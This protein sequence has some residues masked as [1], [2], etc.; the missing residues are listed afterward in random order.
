MRLFIRNM[1]HIIENKMDIVTTLKRPFWKIKR[2]FLYFFP[3][4]RRIRR[5]KDIHKGERC[6]IIGN[7]PSL[8][9]EDLSKLKE[10]NE[11]TFAFN[12]IFHIFEKTDW[13]PTYY[14]TQDVSMMHN[15]Q[16]EINNIPAKAK[17]IPIENKYYKG[18][19]LINA[20]YYHLTNSAIHPEFSEDCSRKLYGSMTVVY[21]AL[22]MAVYMGIH[23][24]YLIGVDHHFNRS[25][26]LKGEIVIDNTVKDYFS[27]K[28]N[29]DKEHLNIPTPEYSE[30]SFIAAKKYAEANGIK[31]FNATR[32]GHLE[33]FS[34]VDFDSL[35]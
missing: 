32:G 3:E 9:P 22:Q 10:N 28:Y 29:I 33:V 11:I 35:F 2:T 5:F 1:F 21:S 20:V 30:F 26:N 15:S 27:E 17:F 12:R 25:K 23:E 6:F 18:I 16:T 14:F 24:I 31:I 7:G 34:R 8:T 19:E 4:G 13:R